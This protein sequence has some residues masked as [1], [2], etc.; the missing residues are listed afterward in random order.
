MLHRAPFTRWS[1]AAAVVA[2]AG[3]LGTWQANGSG[4][5][6]AGPL[7]A[8]NGGGRPLGGVA[9]HTELADDCGACHAPPWGRARM[10]DRCLACHE[11][12]QAEIADTTSLHGRIGSAAGCLACHTEHNGPSG[13]LTRFDGRGFDHAR[14]GF[15]LT[16]GHADL[17]CTECHGGASQ[18]LDF[19]A[20]AA[21]CVDCHREDDPH[22]GELGDAC[23]E[24][25]GPVRWED[26]TFDHGFPLT[27]GSREPVKCDVCHRDAPRSYGTYSCYGCHEHSPEDIR[28]EHLDEGIRDFDD[29][30]S[31]H[32]T[33]REDEAK[34]SA[35]RGRGR[36]EH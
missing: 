23:G 15:P 18:R 31:C 7:H 3:T 28:E 34:K 24:C 20:P 36:A 1:A 19:R 4:M 8:G 10:A 17:A 12:I 35:R 29:C 2:I 5:F 9:S 33:G 6:S 25:H 14:Y 32:P 21:Q 16:G 27:H 22:G 11:D 13:N 26:V 30:M